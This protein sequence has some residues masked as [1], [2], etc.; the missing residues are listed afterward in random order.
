MVP[1]ELQLCVPV[2]ARAHACTVG[3]CVMARGG[4]KACGAGVRRHSARAWAG[5]AARP[6]RVGGAGGT[7]G[8]AA[9]VARGKR[10]A[11]RIAAPVAATTKK[12]VAAAVATAVAVAGVTADKK[13]G[14]GEAFGEE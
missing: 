11:A 5:V 3:W 9:G 6:R 4:A 14:A 8:V 13:G 2:P 12:P 1:S 7:A 10:V